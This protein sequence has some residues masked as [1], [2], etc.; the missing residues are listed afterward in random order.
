MMKKKE[1]SRNI[2]TYIVSLLVVFFVSYGVIRI[3][4]VLFQ[5]N[6]RNKLI[7][8]AIVI[9][10]MFTFA[11]YITFFLR[12]KNKKN[13]I[14]KD[15]R[16][17]EILYDLLHDS[18]LIEDESKLYSLILKSAIKALPQG[19]KGS[20]L[21]IRDLDN[22]KYI[23]MEGFDTEIL[24]QVGFRLEDTYLYNQT[25][26]AINRTVIVENIVE[27]NRKKKVSEQSLNKLIEAGTASIM[28]TI[29]TP[30]S[31][32]GKV[33][34]MI[35]VDSSKVKAFDKESIK[36]I[37]IFSNEISRM[38]DY[39]KI[40]EENLYLSRYDSMTKVYNRG[41]FYEKHKALYKANPVEGY[42]YIA[43]DLN[44]LKLVNDTYGHMIGD[45]MLSHYAKTVQTMIDEETIFGRY[46]GDEFNLLLPGG[47]IQE[48]QAL[49]LKLKNEFDHKPINAQGVAIY[50]SF[51]YGI[52]R[53]PDDTRDYKTLINIGDKRMYA[54]KNR[55]KKVD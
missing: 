15:L 2:G 8:F 18:A 46:G 42:L 27:Y 12:I 22:I 31:I 38:I 48:G 33:I 25:G 36:V 19:D 14:A 6:N 45:Q 34:G 44:N 43:T 3:F 26:G 50:V 28:S 5:I 7:M 10:L 16:L 17:N 39:N 29:S 24:G 41:Y 40:L 23:A 37:E 4:S 51:S 53:Y 32:N 9:T 35:N 54:Y 13:A 55:V 11:Y 49:M 21:D 20:I 47:H 30:V 1:L 52:V